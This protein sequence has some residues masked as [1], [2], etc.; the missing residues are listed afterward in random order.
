MYPY[1]REAEGNS[2]HSGESDVKTDLKM[3]ILKI[4]AIQPQAEECQEP[5]EA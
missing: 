1:D 2:T 3:Q 5:P 4:E